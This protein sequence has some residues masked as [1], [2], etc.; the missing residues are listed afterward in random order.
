V[1]I[2][3]CALLS[4]PAIRNLFPAGSVFA[5]RS[6]ALVTASLGLTVV[7]AGAESTCIFFNIRR[8]NY[9]PVVT[10]DLISRIVVLPLVII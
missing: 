4:L 5:D 3:L 9:R 1:L 10:I 7:L 6:F 8:L 2:G